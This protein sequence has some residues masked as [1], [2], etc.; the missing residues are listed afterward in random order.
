MVRAE[1]ADYVRHGR[2]YL[3]STYP[4]FW[5]LINGAGSTPH[6]SID[7]LEEFIEKK[8][9]GK[10]DTHNS[11]HFMTICVGR[12]LIST[13]RML[14][15][16]SDTAGE[17]TPQPQRLSDILF[18]DATRII[19]LDTAIR[20]NSH[21][22]NFLWLANVQF[23][24]ANVYFATQ[25]SRR[26]KGP[27]VDRAWRAIA[28]SYVVREKFYHSRTKSP[29]FKVFSRF[30]VKA[31]ETRERTL[32][33]A[34]EDPTPPGFIP[35]MRDALAAEGHAGLVQVSGEND[36]AAHL[37]TADASSMDFDF[38]AMSGLDDLLAGQSSVI[39]DGWDSFIS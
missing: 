18:E 25:L 30:F 2:F 38:L 34:G 5:K 1:I 22:M 11:L 4:A 28:A 15:C 3:R 7:E 27:L 31:W 17:S 21:T 37:R 20:T 29:M 6:R 16:L 35:L 32:V 9:L 26:A 14:E 13:W 24:P 33:E 8:Y 19:E 12:G 39:T 36:V 10:C 23:S